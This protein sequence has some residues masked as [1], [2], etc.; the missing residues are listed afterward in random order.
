MGGY[1]FAPNIITLP[2][3]LFFEHITKSEIPAFLKAAKNNEIYHTKYRG[4]SIYKNYEQAAEY[5][6][7]KHLNNFSI[8]G[9][10]LISSQKITLHISTALFSNRINNFLY[11]VDV[12]KELSEM[13][14]FLTCTAE[15]ASHILILNYSPF[16]RDND[17]AKYAQV[18]AEAQYYRS[19]K[20]S[21]NLSYSTPICILI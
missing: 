2:N 3:S 13:A 7:L 9:L 19:N 10:R 12:E 8:D 1:R 17:I 4:R 6:L 20:Y 14:A 18:S 5:F 21:L 16:N 15:K 11:Q